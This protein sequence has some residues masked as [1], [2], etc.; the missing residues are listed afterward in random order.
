M[1][2]SKVMCPACGSY[3]VDQHIDKHTINE[4]YSNGMDLD[5]V[6]FKCNDCGSEGDF[7]DTNDA[8]IDSAAEQLKIAGVKKIIDEFSHLS[9]SMASIERA[10]DLPQR[11][12]SKW[13]S[14]SI[15]PSSS[16]VALMRMIRTFPWLLDVADNKYDHGIALR[17]QINDAM[18]K[19][20]SHITRENLINAGVL[21][22]TNAVMFYAQFSKHA[23]ASSEKV[24]EG[25]L[26]IG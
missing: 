13:K 2:E 22:S 10:L 12:L 7:L 8:L 24:P 11:T 23:D 9:I 1:S 6:I 20:L 17:I 18:Q 16:S 14:G 5:L 3:S 15:S 25:T 26:K 19:V 21:T 4:P